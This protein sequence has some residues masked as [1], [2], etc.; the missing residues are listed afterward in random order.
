MGSVDL[1][2][3]LTVRWPVDGHAYRSR[4]TTR[5]RIAGPRIDVWSDARGVQCR[6]PP[7]EA[8][9]GSLED[10]HEPETANRR[11]LP[12]A[13]GQRRDRGVHRVPG[14]VQHHARACER[15][16]PLPPG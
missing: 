9:P 16:H 12:G 14:P 7:A 3:V 2:K 13:D 8:R 1:L 10:S 5:G 6:S 15:G 4:D 11:V